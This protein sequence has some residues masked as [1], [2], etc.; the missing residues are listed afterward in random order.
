M[1]R[2]LIYTCVFLSLALCAE[3]QLQGKTGVKKQQATTEKSVT[4]KKEYKLNRSNPVNANLNNTTILNSTGTY[5]ALGNPKSGTGQLMISDPTIRTLNQRANM[6]YTSDV[7]GSGII[8]MPKLTYGIAN[9]QIIFRNSVAPTLGT[10]TGS[11]AVG[12]GTN[13]GA[14]G[15]GGNVMG[16]NGKNAYAGPGIYGLPINNVTGPKPTVEGTRPKGVR[17]KD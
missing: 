3:A 12:T 15:T 6:P 9:G 7:P 8:G 4:N 14:M 13:V 16:V 1:K 2:V 17:I 11:G 5:K 10:S